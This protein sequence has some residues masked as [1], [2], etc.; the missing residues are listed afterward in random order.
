[1]IGDAVFRANIEHLVMLDA[2]RGF[3]AFI[4]FVTGCA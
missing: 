1:M 4:Q 3:I 2:V